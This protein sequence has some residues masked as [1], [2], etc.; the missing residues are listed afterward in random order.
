M[1]TKRGPFR[2]S[3]ELIR[4]EFY[5]QIRK[6]EEMMTNRIKLLDDGENQKLTDFVEN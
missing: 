4:Y 5:E 6:N 1:K 3:F 2:S